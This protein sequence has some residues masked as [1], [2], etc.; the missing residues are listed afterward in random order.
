MFHFWDVIDTKGFRSTNAISSIFIVVVVRRLL[1]LTRR[2]NKGEEWDRESEQWPSAELMHNTVNIC[3][4]PPLFFFSGLYYTDVLSALSV[5][6]AYQC[7]LEERYDYYA[8]LAGLLSLLFRQTNIFWVSLFLG[9]LAFCR[10]IPK[11]QA[12]VDFSSKPGLYDVIQ[13]SWQHSMAY[14]PLVREATFEG[15]YRLSV[16][17]YRYR[18]TA[19]RLYRVRSFDGNSWMSQFPKRTSERNTLSAYPSLLFRFRCLEWWSRLRYA[20]LS[21]FHWSNCLC[22]LGD[23][24][25][26][27]VSIHLAQMLYFWPYVVFF[28]IPLLYPYLLD[29]IPQIWI[30][31]ALRSSTIKQQRPRIAI[32][33]PTTA[34]MLAIV[35]YNTIVHP[36]TLADNRHY[37]FYVFRILLRHPLIKYLAVPIYFLCAWAV[38]TALGAPAP[39]PTEST[40]CKREKQSEHKLSHPAP[41][42]CNTPP[43]NSPRT[44]FLLLWLLA[45][46]L[47]VITAPLVEPRYFIVPWLLWR[48]HLPPAAHSNDKATTS[49]KTIFPKT[50]DHRLWL[51]TAWFLLINASVGYIF[52]YRGFAWPQEPGLVQRFMW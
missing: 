14:D 21:A 17:I 50:H 26:H 5:L 39:N 23:K 32:A 9:G 52:L 31:A 18:L 25:N 33:L 1:L 2:K 44:S 22:F 46:S 11:G 7:Y 49:N 48:L 29:I 27:T 35:H 51:E 24:D 41:P 6:H 47:S 36:F 4:F 45:T 19:S 3:L 37:T 40:A 43:N 38:I 12:V 42:P 8:V 28:S 34:I 16:S 20:I 15:C 30:P 13:G 10:A